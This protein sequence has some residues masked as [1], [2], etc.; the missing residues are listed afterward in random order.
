MNVDVA[1]TTLL[2]EALCADI[3]EAFHIRTECHLLSIGNLLEFERLLHTCTL[4]NTAHCLRPLFLGV[5]RSQ[6]E[7]APA[8]TCLRIFPLRLDCHAG[9]SPDDFHFD[10]GCLGTGTE[11]FRFNSNV[12]ERH[13]RAQSTKCQTDSNN[14]T[15]PMNRNGLFTIHECVK[16]RV[17]LGTFSSFLETPC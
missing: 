7:L 12:T 8:N 4:L 17:L 9:P 2:N 14:S 16:R 1:S 3:V 15:T 6:L 13:N 11:L 5:S 10:V